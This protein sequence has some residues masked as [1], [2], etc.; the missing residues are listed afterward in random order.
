MC[1]EPC[2]LHLFTLSCNLSVLSTACVGG[3]LCWWVYICVHM[4]ASACF[5]VLQSLFACWPGWVKWMI[6]WRD[7]EGGLLFPGHAA[8]SLARSLG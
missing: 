4:S 3:C 8:R 2:S 5:V 1:M 7:W 6:V